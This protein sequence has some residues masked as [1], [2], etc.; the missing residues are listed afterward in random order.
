MVID[1]TSMELHLSSGVIAISHWEI[2]RF[3]AGYGYEFFNLSLDGSSYV[4]DVPK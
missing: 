3:D 2:T 1:G 4:R